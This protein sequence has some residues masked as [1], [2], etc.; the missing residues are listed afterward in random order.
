MNTLDLGQPIE[1]W[2]DLENAEKE[3][4]GR[5]TDRTHST[6]YATVSLFIALNSRTRSCTDLS[7][8][9][10]LLVVMIIRFHK[11]LRVV[12]DSVDV[13]NVLFLSIFHIH[14]WV[15][16]IKMVYKVKNSVAE[17]IL[18]NSLRASLSTLTSLRSGETSVSRC[19]TYRRQGNSRSAS[20]RPRT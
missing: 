16:T 6:V 5:S 18:N 15:I 20:W 14:W 8:K 12:D 1:E 10:I 3:E 9:T 4:V 19:G 7:L 11:R 17:L 13:N 2:R